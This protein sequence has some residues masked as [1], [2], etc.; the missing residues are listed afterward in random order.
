MVIYNK[1]TKK[2]NIMTGKIAFM[3]TGGAIGVGIIIFYMFIL[4][5][6]KMAKPEEDRD[7]EDEIK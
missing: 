5:L 7:W 3:I 4:G 1:I 2:G 6:C